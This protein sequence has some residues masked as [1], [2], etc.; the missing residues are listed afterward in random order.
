[1]ARSEVKQRL[2]TAQQLRRD[3]EQELAIARQLRWT[4]MQDAIKELHA[5]VAELKVATA[6]KRRRP[7]RKLR[8]R[9][10]R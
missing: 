6:S 2:A 7:R 8:R 1:M 9:R 3:A 10:L 5:E 4:A